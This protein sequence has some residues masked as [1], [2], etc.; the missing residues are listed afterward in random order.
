MGNTTSNSFYSTLHNAF[1]YDPFKHQLTSESK[2][3][4]LLTFFS[5]IPI[6]ST[7]MLLIYPIDSTSIRW[8]AEY[9][10]MNKI[11]GIYNDES[12]VKSFFQMF[13]LVKRKEGIGGYYK[14]NR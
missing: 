3:I 11:D 9:R 10:P 4:N 8:E 2:F 1:N 14:G 5:M 7:I 13:T 6:M 12:E